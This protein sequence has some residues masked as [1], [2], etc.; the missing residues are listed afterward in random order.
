MKLKLL[1]KGIAIVCISG[2]LQSHTVKKEHIY[3]TNAVVNSSLDKALNLASK[4]AVL[5]LKEGTA[6]RFNAAIVPDANNILYVNKTA[7]GNSSGNSW[8]NAIPE[9]AD[10]LIW[11]N[12]NKVDFTT[13]PLQI[14]VAGGTYKPLYSPE[15]GANFGTDQTRDNTFLLVNNVE[16]YGG[17]AG[18]ETA[19]ADRNLSLTANKT[20]L[21]G[22]L[23]TVDDNTDNTYHVVVSAGEVGSAK[24][25]GFNLVEGNANYDGFGPITVN[26]KTIAGYYGGGMV[27]KESSPSLT[28]VSLSG[29]TA[30]YDGGGMYNYNS[31]ATLTNVSLSGNTASYGGGM[32]NYNSDPIMYN[33]NSDPILTNV[34]LSGNTAS[35]GG[36]M[37]N[38]NSS[39]TLTNTILL[40]NTA[41]ISDAG[42]YNVGSGSISI[43]YSLV[44]GQTN[45]SNGNIDATGLTDTDIFK[46]AANGDYSLKPLGIAVNAGSNTLYNNAGGNLTTDID[47]TGNLR[48]FQNTIDIGAYESQIPILTPDANNII[49]VNKT[50]TGNATGNSW[51]N[52]TPELA[53]ALIW[54]NINKAN[55]TTTP[56]QIWVAGGTYKPLYS[57]EDGVNFG[58]DQARDNAFLMVNNVQLYGGFAGTEATLVDRDLSLIA[59]KTTLSGDFGTEDVITGSGE[60][61]SIT[62]NETNAAHVIV[63]VGDVGTALLDGFTITGGNA[64]LTGNTLTINGISTLLYTGGGMLNYSSSPKIKNI[65]FI[66]NTGDSGGGM[67]NDESSPNIT[68]TAFIDNNSADGGGIFNNDSSS[69]TIINCIFSKNASNRGG[70]MFNYVNSSPIIINTTFSENTTAL[71]YGDAMQN[72]GASNPKIYNSIVWGD[73]QNYSS[74]NPDIKNSI[75]KGN[76][77]TTNGNIDATNLSDK[78]IFNN[79]TNGDYSLNGFGPALNAGDNTL[80]TGTIAT[81]KDLAG[82]A[83]LF[84]GVPDPDVIDMG[85]YEYQ[86]E[87]LKITATNNVLYVNK[88]AIGNKTGDSWANAL[89]ELADALVWANNNKTNFTTTPLQIWVASGTYKPLY[90]PEDGANFGTDQTRDNTFLLVNNVE[91]YGGFAGTETAVADRN[92]SLTANKTTLS[93]DLGTVDDNTDNT[94]HVVVSAGEVGSAKLDGFNLVEG[95]ANYDSFGSITVNTKTI[96]RYYGGGM[97]NKESSPSLTNVKLR[98][99]TAG[100]GGGLYNYSNSNTILTNV[101][102]S[103]NTATYEGGGMNNYDSDPILTNVSLS[104]NTASYGGGMYNYNSSATLTNTILL[105]NTA[106]TSDAGIYNRG[107]G[108]ISITYSLVQGQTNA[109]NGNIDATGVT[110][111]DLF[112]DPANG[113]YSLKAGSIAINAGD[114][115]LYTNA[116]GNLTTDKDLAGNP[117]VFQSTIDIGAYESPVLVIT[118][119]TNNI[120][121]VNKTATGDGSGSSWA[122]AIPELADALVWANNNKTN[123]T[124]TPLQ[125]WVASGT[126]KPLYSP[127]DGANFGTDQARDNAFLMVNNVQLYGGFAGTEATLVDR[128][129]SLIAN[130]TTLSGD[131]NNDDTITG[132]G[133]TLSI[134]SNTEN[135]YHVIVSSGNVEAALLDGFSITSGNATDSSNSSITVNSNVI[136][137]TFGGGIYNHTSSLRITNVTFTGNSGSYGGAI[138]NNN[139]SPII[140]NSSF[141]KNKGVTRGGA[142]SNF[143]SASPT[144]YNSSF[145]GNLANEAGAISL[146]PTTSADIINCTIVGNKATTN[147]DGIQTYLATLNIYNSIIWNVIYDINSSQNAY[148]LKNS[149]IKD[150]TDATNGNIDATNLTATDLFTDSTNGDYS[151]TINSAAVNSGDNALYTGTLATD[152]DLAGNPRVFQNT[153]DLG[154]YEA[155]ALVI[156]PDVNNIVYVN[157]TATRNGTGDSWANALPELADVLVWANNNKTNFTTTPLQIWVASGTYKPLYSPEDGA[158]FGTDQARD[159]SFLLVKNV[160]L[161]GGFAGTE[162]NLADR[163]LSLTAN[164]SIL[165]GD[166]G[167]VND[168]T[169][170]ANNVVVSFGAAGTARLDGFTVSNGRA[171][172]SRT[173][174]INNTDIRRFVGGG[175]FNRNSSPTI[176][177]TIFIG[178]KAN[179]AG[180]GMFNL[181]SSPTI[182]NT[183][184]IDNSIISTDGKGGGM[185]NNSS[186]SP[187]ITNTTF[188]GN[189]ATYGSGMANQDNSNAIVNNTIVTGT[190]SNDNAT[191]LYKN[192]II[193]DK[194]YGNDGSETTTSLTVTELF[195]DPTNGD[196]SLNRYSPAVNAG[197]N[198]LYTGTLATDKDL[199]GNARVFDG[200][201]TIDVIDMGAYEFQAEP[202][203]ITPTDNI[204][205]VNKNVSGGNHTGD[206]WANAISELADALLW[207]K[208]NYDASWATT[209]LQ[210]FVAKGTYKPM[211]SPEDGTNFGSDQARNNSFLMVKNVQLYGG[212]AGTE[213]TL[214]DR[215]LNLV[216]NK[217]V[218]S[219]EIGNTSVV[220]DNTYN[221]FISSGLAG[222][223]ILDGFSITGGYADDFSNII[224]NENQ[225][226]KCSGSG[227]YNSVSSPLYQNILFS[228]NNCTESGGGMFNYQSSPSLQ[229]I[230]FK[231]NKAKD[232]GGITNQDNSAPT[233][234]NSLFVNNTATTDGGAIYNVAN[235]SPTLVNITVVGNNNTD[236][237]LFNE[238]TSNPSLYNSIIWGG[239]T[240][241]YQAENSII[242]GNNNTIN[243]NIDAANLT[244]TNLFKDPANGD[245]SLFKFSPAVNAGNNALY[246]ATLATDKDLAGNTRLFDGLPDPDVIDIG[247]YEFQAAPDSPSDYFITTWKTD[248]EGKS[249]NTSITIPTTGTGYSYDIDWE[250]DGVFDEFNLTGNSTHDYGTAGTYTVAIRGS[251]PR[252]YFNNNNNDVNEVDNGNNNTGEKEKIIYI[253]QWGT[254][255]WTSMERAFY[256][257]TNLVGNFTDKPDLSGVTNMSY[258]F[259]FASSFNQDIGN[260][261]VANV[262]NMLGTFGLAITFNQDISTWNVTNVT[263]MT[264]MFAGAEKFNKNI[265]NWNVGSVTDMTGMFTSAIAFDQDI[266]KWDVSNVTDMIIMFQ[267]ATAFDQDI[268]E[269][270]VSKVTSM[271]NMFADVTL[272]TANYDAL[273]IGWS[274]KTLQENVA[275]NGGNSKYCSGTTA[276]QKIITDFNWTITDG[277]SIAGDITDI[278]DLSIQTQYTFPTIAGTNLTGTEAYYTETTGGGTKYSS[279]DII[280]YTDASSYP[281]TLYMYD[282]DTPNCSDEESFKLTLTAPDQTGLSFDDNSF[283]YDGSEKSLIVTG[284]ASDATVAYENNDQTSAGTYTVRATVTRPNYVAQVLTATLTINKADAIITAD[285]IQTFTY[286]GT[287]K[288]V[289]VSLNHSETTLTYNSQQGY[290]NAG[291]Y[292]I[293]VDAIET[294]NYLAASQNVSLVIEAATESGLEFANNS[295]TYDGT[296]KSLIVTGQAED[297]T[298]VYENNDQTNAGTYNVIARVSRPNYQDAV[299]NAILTI[300]KAQSVI[301]ADATQTFTFDGTIKNI[302]ASLNHSE[303][304][305]TYNSQQGYTDAGGYS[306]NIESSETANYSAGSRNVQLVINKASQTITFSVLANKNLENDPDFQ[307]GATA[308]SGLPITYSYTFTSPQPSATVSPEGFV[309]LQTSG[310][311][312]I[313]AI[314]SGNSNYQMARAVERTLNITSSNATASSITI[315]GQLYNNPTTQIYYL[316]DC[317]T[318]F[319]SVDV[320]L[321]TEPNAQLSTGNS[322]TIATPAPG[323]YSQEVIVTSQDG[324]QT[325]TYIVM[326]EKAFNFEDIVTQKY[327]NSLVVNNNPNTNGGYQFVSYEWFK[328][329]RSVGTGQ[330]F[331][332]GNRESDILD[333]TATYMVKMTTVDGDVLQTCETSIVLKNSYSMVIGQNPIKQ[334]RN[335]NVQADYPT[336]ELKRAIYHIYSVSGRLIMSHPVDGLRTSINLPGNLPTGIYRLLLVT[337]E[338]TVAKNFIKN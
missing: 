326:V 228:D 201:P 261:D 69:P 188:S 292:A 20:T 47:G 284:Q 315:D 29:N 325:R 324:T 118:P 275:F 98:G 88:A 241:N 99:N 28:N 291:T 82:N 276:R 231:N 9:L 225:V 149:I 160:Q 172:D 38:Y 97:F 159:N 168:D 242:E 262:T 77:D 311:I 288:N 140:N 32:Y 157:K 51:A 307:L 27:N 55:F 100:Y 151:L 237:G 252:I 146:D 145:I 107:S 226:F 179:I 154:A 46:D 287:V 304:T 40:G 286:D 185:F 213:I 210:I 85:A 181:N 6:V 104:G 126:Y 299:L 37:Y 196:Y 138:A 233:I 83:R 186:S 91:L 285:A 80:Y 271:T 152:K 17:F 256:G 211:Y 170:N 167:A 139:S 119:D 25:D 78:D 183:T 253:E 133:S 260:W 21:S 128:D 131:F 187:I 60:S 48:V 19:V 263:N 235:S 203:N 282:A 191:P 337:P 31:S 230:V 270:D 219:G 105:G 70:A 317:D 269:W 316:I 243:G 334:G 95:N 207:A 180:G 195:N 165:S 217:S 30:S 35:Y 71:P 182:T 22:D 178:N 323:I 202:I 57:P 87:P 254:N 221:V 92:L 240:G 163:D 106:S 96:A 259:A 73:I 236:G 274:K 313:T 54:A 12:N 79:L 214:A 290:T 302:S 15:D 90:S 115:T 123:F 272:S 204:V 4:N 44:Q 5:D 64:N 93:G 301:T 130:K 56:L 7:T 218:L 298:V 63:S 234:L 244:L 222:E 336:S 61:L 155:Q 224:I 329:G 94:Y 153:I 24:L 293:S 33:Y 193:A 110:D 300:D 268:S 176:T 223:A 314:Q 279:G 206:S 189:S 246:S 74:S 135:A 174:S 294:D 303:T 332:E 171:N 308:S 101:S 58:T 305:L 26:T 50:A 18:T 143:S 137:N 173:F 66:A 331:S 117:R 62:E 162:T 109:S 113:D 89:P 43:T 121:Y 328:N 49:Y 297:A 127:E 190:I 2:V 16:L 280:K 327:N 229:N 11:A 238:D 289:M 265:G 309:V 208:E 52:A 125:I 277:G 72:E 8:A 36:G 122:N 39:A 335:L 86:A 23:G 102:L 312:Q 227:I 164:K 216:A 281:I 338:R 158:N 232:G 34:S 68:N 150:H 169:D 14:W 333:P 120:L 212:F 247:A 147:G 199:A 295:F 198:T 255:S 111:T 330:V 192:S 306:I 239:T 76:S 142:I 194:S 248:N 148:T 13:T 215:D 41:S 278:T 84:V 296:A 124:T 81:D 67:F 166:I 273:L 283:T 175:M 136:T 200:L 134:G 184:F 3:V 310:Q 112:K 318:R 197:N 264:V 129:L 108:S 319:S 114:N 141:N 321:I 10:A 177:N 75:V 267:S 320:S 144:I 65:N 59:N 220:T 205:Y 42:I 53:G 132:S 266:S 251:F 161:Y 103:G 156:T 116:G 322:F 1:L 257:C 209:P 245:Y 250:N 258:M 45:A 249:N